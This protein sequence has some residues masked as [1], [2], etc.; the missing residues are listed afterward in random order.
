MIAEHGPYGE[1][2]DSCASSSHASAPFWRA[3]GFGFADQDQ[4]HHGGPNRRDARIDTL[5][6]GR[7]TYEHMAASWPTATEND[8]ETIECVNGVQQ[9]AA[10][11]TLQR[12]DWNNPLRHLR[13]R[14]HGGRPDGADAH[15]DLSQPASSP[16]S[17]SDGSVSDGSGSAF[18]AASEGIGR[19]ADRRSAC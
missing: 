14:R 8:P 2:P 19:A 15:G 1:E 3:V 12:T 5:V 18:A 4:E 10:F 16:P 6:F 7:E 13:D 17:G 11:T 9:I